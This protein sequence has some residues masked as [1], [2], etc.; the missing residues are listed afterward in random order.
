MDGYGQCD[1]HQRMRRF[2][3]DPLLPS[4]RIGELH[5]DHARCR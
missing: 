4:Q 3:Q 5:V 1:E 2:E